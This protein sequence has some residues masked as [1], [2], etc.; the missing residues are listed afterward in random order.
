MLGDVE[1]V[2]PW[3]QGPRT[4]VQHHSAA[5]L[6]GQFVQDDEEAEAAA[7][8]TVVQRR[9]MGPVQRHPMAS[10]TEWVHPP[11]YGVRKIAEAT[12][13]ATDPFFEA[14]IKVPANRLA[15]QVLDAAELPAKKQAIARM[16]YR[17]E[18]WSPEDSNPAQTDASGIRVWIGHPNYYKPDGSVAVAFL[19]STLL[20]EALHFVSSNHQGFQGVE[21]FLDNTEANDT[22][23]EAVTEKVSHELAATVLDPGEVYTTNYW[24]LRARRG[25]DFHLT[26]TGLERLATGSASLW[27]GKMVDVIIDKTGLSWAT[28]R[29]AFLSDTAAGG[30][31]AVRATVESKRAEIAVAW[32]EKREA[33]LK[34]QLGADAIPKL[35]WQQ[36]LTNAT[37]AALGAPGRPPKPTRDQIRDMVNAELVATAPGHE[38]VSKAEPR[39]SS[40][41]D[42]KHVADTAVANGIERK[43]ANAWLRS[44]I[45]ELAVVE[46]SGP[47]LPKDKTVVRPEMVGWKDAVIPDLLLADHVRRSNVVLGDVLKR[48]PMSWVIVPPRSGITG[49]TP[50]K[51]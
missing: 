43:D 19:R 48:F 12:R 3:P 2:R 9:S 42:S 45:K 28:I 22:I 8:A 38:I 39:S 30:N 7:D 14:K 46:A 16:S 5:T 34:A 18:R 13:I 21:K 33:A 24:N 17:I 1:L 31:A 11:S 25:L 32:K 6:K 35:E 23:D 20:H 40:L 44:G 15:D 51:D 49:D 37:V 47:A 36:A 27:L 26:L 41:D 10:T 50:F 29:K 4:S